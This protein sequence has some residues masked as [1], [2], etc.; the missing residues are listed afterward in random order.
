MLWGILEALYKAQKWLRKKMKMWRRQP[1]YGVSKW[2]TDAELAAAG[3]FKPVGFVAGV[4][5]GKVIY[6][7][8]EFVCFDGWDA[9]FRKK[10]DDVCVSGSGI[11]TEICCVRPS[12]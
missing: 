6:S 9:R 3:H 11:W 7:G 1:A 5:N 4:R 10:P 2:A 12:W 8:P